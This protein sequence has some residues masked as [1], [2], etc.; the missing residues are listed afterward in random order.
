[1]KCSNCGFEQESGFAFCP[2]CGS[3]A[4]VNAPEGNNANQVPPQEN[5]PGGPMPVPVNYVQPQPQ[6]QPAG[7][8]Y[9]MNPW[10]RANSLC[11][12][13]LFL[14]VCILFSVNA[15]LSFITIIPFGISVIRILLVI[16][17]WVAFAAARKD[18]LEAKHVRWI[19]GTC[20]A[21]KIVQYV[22]VALVLA[23][24]II[25][26][27]LANSSAVSALM[28]EVIMR[29]PEA[30]RY[31]G[32]I[33]DI[34]SAS[35]VVFLVICIIIALIIFLFAFFGYRSFHLFAKSAYRSMETGN[36]EIRKRGAAAGW[37]MAFGII[38]GLGALASMVFI[39]TLISNGAMC[40]GYIILSILINRYY[41]DVR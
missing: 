18:R 36:L 9:G 12:D 20:A 13:N 17:F 41:G 27:L 40:A 14:T 4:P 6:P 19:S 7:M 3:P 30:A 16:F 1:M 8:A 10:Q 33:V 24:G 11:K 37:L 31:G 15:A 22:I 39:I 21:K 29:A 32:Y 25:V 5:N 28:Q 23:A 35:G 38:T 26:M 2:E 34:I